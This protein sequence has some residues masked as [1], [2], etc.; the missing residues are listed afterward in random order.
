MT[1]LF[2]C[3]LSI[4]EDS[5]SIKKVFLLENKYHGK[6][7]LAKIR[8]VF[9]NEKNINEDIFLIYYDHIFINN[10]NLGYVI[11]DNGEVE[12]LERYKKSPHFDKLPFRITSVFNKKLN[13]RYIGRKVVLKN[14]NHLRNLIKNDFSGCEYDKSLSRI[15]NL[16]ERTL[17]IFEIAITI[18]K[19]ENIFEDDLEDINRYLK[20]SGISP[21][22][23]LHYF[24][25]FY[26]C[27]K[28]A[29]DF[30][31]NLNYLKI[32]NDDLISLIDSILTNSRENKHELL[33]FKFFLDEKN[34][35]QDNLKNNNDIDFI[36]RDFYEN[37]EVLFS[38][39]DDFIDTMA[40]NNKIYL[41]TGG[42]Y[43]IEFYVKRLCNLIKKTVNSICEKGGIIELDFENYIS[44]RKVMAKVK[45]SKIKVA[46]FLF[47]TEHLSKHF[48]KVLGTR[49][50]TLEDFK[51]VDKIIC[52]YSNV[53]NYVF[54][55]KFK[56]QQDSRSCPAFYDPVFV[57][58]SIYK[59]NTA[60]KIEIEEN[61][62][63]I[64]I[65][66]FNDKEE[67]IKLQESSII[68]QMKKILFI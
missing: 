11:F 45:K 54:K 5:I 18:F 49:F 61:A 26:D 62:D 68:L 21:M 29:K 32:S 52:D 24:K 53:L 46:R 14:Q 63:L 16:G 28:N 10:A 20:D 33:E 59:I 22:F 50:K 47:E 58:E 3:V 67:M 48:S 65:K 39:T 56:M 1:I 4:R 57:D 37:T 41:L 42:K 36:D 2:G 31:E 25:N 40:Q 38:N 13:E 19:S 9:E 23:T 8:L 15:F 43:S 64:E 17:F 34:I 12:R 51:N 55:C 60:L 27:L 7:R 66:A 35:N 6:G 44:S 30:F